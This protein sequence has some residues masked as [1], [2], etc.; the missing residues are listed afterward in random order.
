ML[1]ELRCDRARKRAWMDRL[2]LDVGGERADTCIAWADGGEPPAGLAAL[3]ELERLLLR[4]GRRSGVE[5][6]QGLAAEAEHGSMPDIVIDFTAAPRAAG[7]SARM[8]LR[9]LYNGAAGEDAALAAILAGELPLIEIIDEVS[10]ATLDQGSPSAEI[11]AG[12]S[13][14]LEAVQARTMTLLRAILSGVPRLPSG[15]RRSAV[16]APKTT[17][18]A[19]VAGGLAHALARRIYH[20][21]CYAPHWHIGWRYGAGAGVWEKGDLSGAPWRRLADPGHRFFADPFPVTWQGRTFVYFE[22][23]DHRV[24]KGTISAI[25]FDG[26]GPIG[27]VIPVLDLPW[28]LSYP[29]LIEDGGELWMIPESSANRDVALYRCVAFPDT[30]ERHAT[31]LSGLE[32]G[33]ATVTR[34]GGLYYLFGAVRD[35]AGGYSDTLAIYYAERLVGPW[36]PHAANPILIDRAQARPAG[37]MIVHDGRLWRPVQD[38]TR[39]YGAALALAEVLELSPTAFRQQVRHTVQ[40]GPAWP[41]RKLHTLNR[42]GRLEVIDG[43]RMQPKWIRQG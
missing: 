26:Q 9:P 7:G 13:G 43:S 11:A 14:H 36:L 37:N 8:Y 40:P 12:L 18:L 6:A 25:E 22:D 28:H 2:A 35:G 1:I 10:G 16:R 5:P 24:G 3:F 41:G 19:Y 15:Q 30:W 21:C 42:V 4:R 38:C 33:D 20:L 27:A 17:P 23:L 32:L 34:H 29:F 39:G 31:L